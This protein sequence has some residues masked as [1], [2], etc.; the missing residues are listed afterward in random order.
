MQDDTLQPLII[1]CM[2]AG[3]LWR[4]SMDSG[5]LAASVAASLKLVIVCSIVGVALRLD[6][7]P[8]DTGVVMSKV[9][10]NFLM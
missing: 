5:V 6:R 7:I 3:A 9:H 8:A 10:S 1:A 4:Q 2:H